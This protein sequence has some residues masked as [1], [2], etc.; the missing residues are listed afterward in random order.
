MQILIAKAVELLNADPETLAG[1]RKKSAEQLA[2]QERM[3]R[4]Q[5]KPPIE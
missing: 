1:I 5:T 3:K 4:K 2:F